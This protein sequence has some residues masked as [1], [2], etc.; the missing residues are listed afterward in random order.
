[1]GFLPFGKLMVAVGAIGLLV[2]GSTIANA[3]NG[4]AG[5]A[6]VI[7]RLRFSVILTVGFLMI[8]FAAPTLRCA[9]GRM[10]PVGLSCAVTDSAV[11]TTKANTEKDPR[12]GALAR[13]AWTFSQ[14]FPEEPDLVILSPVR[15]V[16][17]V[18]AA[19]L[20]AKSNQPDTQA[21]ILSTGTLQ[22]SMNRLQSPFPINV[23]AGENQW[24]FVVPAIDCGGVLFRESLAS[25]ASGVSD[26]YFSLC[27]CAPA[28]GSLVVPFHAAAPALIPQHV[29]LRK[30][31]LG[32]GRGFASLR[33]G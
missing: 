16:A 22:R 26:E 23:M 8:V 6:G 32:N 5:R 29:F 18:L 15:S 1:M 21:A 24:G 3:L 2:L 9:S 28:C 11:K 20:A 25:A 10:G 12:E 13:V 4:T 31:R 17:L 7:T 30:P 14:L 19:S 33:Q 27:R